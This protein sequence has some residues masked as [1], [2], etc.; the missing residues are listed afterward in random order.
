[1][2]INSIVSYRGT[3]IETQYTLTQS[4]ANNI[5]SYRGTWIETD[6]MQTLGSRSKIVS[7]RGTW[8]E[9]CC[10]DVRNAITTSYL[11]EVRGLKPVYWAG[12]LINDGR[13]L[14]RYVD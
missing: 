4:T 13:I 1:M 11:I 6:R 3:W 10:C 9:T 2:D 14:Q 7:Y 8:I 12:A 5:V